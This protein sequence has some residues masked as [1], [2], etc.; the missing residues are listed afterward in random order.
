MATEN[1]GGS[2]VKC[3]EVDIPGW[4]QSLPAESSA[5]AELINCVRRGV[6]GI[7]CAEDC[8]NL[9]SVTEGCENWQDE[10]DVEVF[11]EES[12]AVVTAHIKGDAFYRLLSETA[13]EEIADECSLMRFVVSASAARRDYE[14]VKDALDCARVTGYGIVRPSDEDLSLEKPSSFR[15]GTNV[16]VKLKANAPAYHIIKVD[17]SGEVSPIMGSAAQG[18]GMVGEIMKGFE[19]DPD[20]MWNTNFFGKTLK[21]MVQEGLSGKVSGMA[22]DTRSKLRKA[23]TKIVNEGRGGVICILL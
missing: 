4:V 17:V 19:S 21:D 6:E 18:E 14:K 9:S 3:I 12:K 15:Q 7:T 1:I 23:I 11:P 5:V 13:G 16:G 8:K 22:D 10:C 20:G 2:P